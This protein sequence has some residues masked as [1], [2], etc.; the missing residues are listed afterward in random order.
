[1]TRRS[2]AGPSM[3]CPN[4]PTRSATSS[5]WRQG[6]ARPKPLRRCRSSPGR[7][8]S[9]ADDQERAGFRSAC[10]PTPSSDAEARPPPRKA[11]CVPV[12]Q[13]RERPHRATGAPS[14]KPACAPRYLRDLGNGGWGPCGGRQ[15]VQSCRRIQ[16]RSYPRGRG[17]TGN[18]VWRFRMTAPYGPG[19]LSANLP[20]IGT[21]S[22]KQEWWRSW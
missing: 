3:P 18:G 2:G 22:R 16:P 9:P 8:H 10:R 19:D 4:P 17:W 6:S 11:V 20:R 13:V 21:P 5:S 1:M 14:L 15:W 7:P 12:G